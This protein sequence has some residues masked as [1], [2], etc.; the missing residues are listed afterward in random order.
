VEV[1]AARTVPQLVAGLIGVLK[2][3]PFSRIVSIAPLVA[4]EMTVEV[5][6][7]VEQAALEMET[8]G[9]VNRSG[10]SELIVSS[11]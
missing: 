9:S 4:G 6:V 2:S 7:E 10:E 5:T 8:Q 11:T 1:L 3:D